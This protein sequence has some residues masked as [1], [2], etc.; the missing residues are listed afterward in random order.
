MK[1]TW[2]TFHSIY[3][4]SKASTCLEHYLQWNCNRATALQ[5]TLYAIYQMPFA[6]W[7]W[8]SNARNM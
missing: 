5:L 3:W 2:C 1:P 4:E 6:S 8:A 7:E